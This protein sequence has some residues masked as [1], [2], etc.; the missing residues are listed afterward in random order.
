MLDE[1][2]YVTGADEETGEVASEAQTTVE[3]QWEN[4]DYYSYE[5]SRDRQRS[6]GRDL[7]SREWSQPRRQQAADFIE[8]DMEREGSQSSELS[9]VSGGYRSETP[10]DWEL[11][12]CTDEET[13]HGDRSNVKRWFFFSL[14]LWFRIYIYI[15]V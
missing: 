10:S 8:L 14:E 7:G 6:W 9:P 1:G 4:P 15:Y 12:D 13:V 2:L 5:R 11:K 3:L